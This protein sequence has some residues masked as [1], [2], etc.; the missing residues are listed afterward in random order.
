M[1]QAAEYRAD[2]A[3]SQTSQTSSST[4]PSNRISYTAAIDSKSS[5]ILEYY[6]L[7]PK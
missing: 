7:L 5:K 4:P 1:F 2:S 3:A 6:I